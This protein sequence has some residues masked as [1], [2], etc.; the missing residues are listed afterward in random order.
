METLSSS[1]VTAVQISQWT[2]QDAILSK[3]NP[4][5]S[6]SWVESCSRRHSYYLPPMPRWTLYL[7][8]LHSS[9]KLSNHS[10]RGEDPSYGATPWRTPWCFQDEILGSIICLVAW[11]RPW[12]TGESKQC[13]PCQRM[14]HNP[15]S[16]LLDPWEFLHWPWER[17][18][19]GFTCKMFLA[20]VT[21]IQNMLTKINKPSWGRNVCPRL[22]RGTIVKI[23]SCDTI[24]QQCSRH[25][26][27]YSP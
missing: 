20:V 6:A 7:G 10:T 8:W 9:W 25:H 12:L 18:H 4:G 14:R 16:A 3:V 5:I 21:S 15:A 13:D 26:Y 11:N 19:A 2:S 22:S 24:M 17:L 23:I 27:S 1:P